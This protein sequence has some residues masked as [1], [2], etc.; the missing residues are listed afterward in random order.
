MAT[1]E[2]RINRTRITVSESKQDA[3]LLDVKILIA[4]VMENGYRLNDDSQ[5]IP[6]HIITDLSVS[7]NSAVVFSLSISTGI[8]ANPIFMFPIKKPERPS[9]LAVAWIDDLGEKGF[10]TKEI[11]IQ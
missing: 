8:A 4:H 5:R 11:F 7:L 1:L 2:N 6:A 9:K 10:A 3:S